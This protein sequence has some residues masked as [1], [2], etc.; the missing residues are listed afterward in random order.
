VNVFLIEVNLDPF[1]PEVTNVNDTDIHFLS[2]EDEKANH[3]MPY[4]SR[5]F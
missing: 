5:W 1:S 3:T 4:V 2:N